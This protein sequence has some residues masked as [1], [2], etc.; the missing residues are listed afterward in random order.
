MN[1]KVVI[2]LLVVCNV[3]LVVA[4]LSCCFFTMHKEK[5]AFVNSSK[6]LAQFMGM[7]ETQEAYQ[8]KIA[9]KQAKLDTMQA[10][11]D[12]EEEVYQEKQ[13]ELPAKE[14][15]LIEEQLYK[16]KE[17]FIK[18][19]QEWEKEVTIEGNELTQ[20]MLNQINTYIESY[21]KEHGYLLV[22]GSSSSG[23]ILYADPSVDIT[24]EIIKGLNAQYK[25]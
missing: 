18:Q 11:I 2:R 16:S 24:E 5:S 9:D 25:K 13:K 12:K 4:M 14:R 10:Q 17:H 19:K 3:V 23:S 20:G 22:H 8:K 1:Q 7:K 6:V 15:Q 21:A